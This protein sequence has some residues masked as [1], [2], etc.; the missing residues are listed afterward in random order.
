MTGK[1]V[2][3]TNLREMIGDDREAENQLF[4]AFFEG[5]EGCLDGMT[6]GLDTED[7]ELWRKSAHSF[8]GI[9]RN[10]GAY[11]LGDLCLAAQENFTCNSEQKKKLL[12]TIRDEYANVESYL[13]GLMEPQ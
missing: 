7:N 12:K 6:Q 9:S 4:E 13:K 10:L 2:D 1:S 5:A 8:K 11:I 3:L